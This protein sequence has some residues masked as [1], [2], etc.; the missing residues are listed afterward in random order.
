MVLRIAIAM[1]KCDDP[2]W[3]AMVLRW[4]AI[5]ATLEC[6]GLSSCDT[7]IKQNVHIKL[8]KWY[9]IIKICLNK[10]SC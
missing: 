6:D 5:V 9:N 4:S 10:S 1:L 8:F 2:R 3:S 7:S